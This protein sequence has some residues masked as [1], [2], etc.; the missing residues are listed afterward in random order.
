MNINLLS[1]K[2]GI[3]NEIIID[4]SYSFPQDDLTKVGIIELKNGLVKG[5]IT[6]DSLTELILDLELT[7]TMVLPCAR[8]LEPVD[9]SFQVNIS[10]NLAKIYEEIGQKD[11]K[12]DNAI[13]ILPIIWENILMEIPIRVVSDK[14]KEVTVSGDGWRLITDDEEEINP[15]LAKLKDLL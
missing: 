10:G 7:G 1:L 15:E 9:Y 5:N 3:D 12:V 2:N 8:T 14:A 13:D 6:M 4:Q 11:K